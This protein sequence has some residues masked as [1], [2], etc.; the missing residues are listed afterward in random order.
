MG[1]TRQFTLSDCKVIA[2]FDNLSRALNLRSRL[3]LDRAPQPANPTSDAATAMASS[4]T[5]NHF[6]S[7]CERQFSEEGRNRPPKGKSSIPII[8]TDTWSAS[9]W[10][11]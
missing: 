10:P 5:D 7:R 11:R 1:I 6:L 8:S 9:I 4:A 2:E 3:G